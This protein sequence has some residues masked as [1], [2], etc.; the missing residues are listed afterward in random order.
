MR[1][2][3]L[4]GSAFGLAAIAPA[5]AQPIPAEDD[6]QLEEIVVTA[7][8][9]SQSLQDVPAA[10]SA[11]S[12]EALSDLQNRTIEDVTAQ[13][14]GLS[15]SRAGGQSF[16]YLRGIGSDTQGIGSDASVGLSLDGVYVSRLEFGATQFFDLDRVEVLRGPQGTLYGRNATGG[17][18]NILSR[19]PTNDPSFYARAA[20]GSFDRRDVEA[21]AGGGIGGGFAVRLAGRYT[22][23]NGFTDDLDPRGTNRIDD[24]DVWALRGSLAGELGERGRLRLIVDHTRFKSG[25]TSVLPL[26]TL[27]RAQALGAVPTQFGDTRNDLDTFDRWDTTGV[28]GLID[29]D[30]AQDLTLSVVAGYREYDQ[31]FLFNTDGTEID[32]T[33]TQFARDYEQMSMEAR[34]AYSDERLRLVGGVFYMFEDKSGTLGLV[35]VAPL[36]VPST[37]LFPSRNEGEA[38]AGFVDGTLNLGD[39]F[40]VIAGVRYSE[41]TKRDETLSASVPDTLGLNSPLT[42]AVNGRRS[43]FDKYTA[44]TPRFGLEFRPADDVMFYATAS[45]GFKSGGVN[46]YDVRASFDPE[47]VWAYEAGVKS[48]LF[49]RRLRLNASAFHYDY[50]DLQVSIFLNGFTFISNAAAADIDGV[51]V[52]GVA[53]ITDGLDVALSAAWLDAKY[54][55]FRTPFGLLPPAVPGGP[56]APSIV[57]V[58]GNRLRNAPEWKLTGSLAYE[59]DLT[60]SLK[61]DAQAQA[62]YQS[63]VFFSPINENVAS[64]DPLTLVDA[65]IGIGATDD[66]WNIAVIGKNLTD[67]DYFS[68]VVRFT[69]TSIP[70]ADPSNIGNALGYPQPGRSINVQLSVKY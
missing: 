4:L 8:K 24:Q 6:A 42:P 54:A 30:V 10:V 36:P 68:N 31:E 56:R 58:S 27:G 23:D 2:A 53:R 37:F 9:V 19:A 67:E 64:N 16:I 60:S 47:F 5:A 66:R 28:T 22:K 18:I 57:D 15:F 13:T 1:K 35:R 3:L 51:E 59:R 20:Y 32:V 14:P 11:I 26:D 65:R 45:R 34:L 29:L 43:S 69:S 7:Q 46:S 49:D 12:G 33:R 39:R 62:N 55:N 63:R 25:N 50:T 41:E 48:E 52:E 21:A 44:W 70:S 61:L 38:I 17:V 40:A